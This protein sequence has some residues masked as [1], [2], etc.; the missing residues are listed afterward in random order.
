[1]RCLKN[2]PAFQQWFKANTYNNSLEKGAG[3]TII[4]DIASYKA[5]QCAGLEQLRGVLRPGG[6]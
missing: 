1:M 5:I 3:E 6:A 4:A 2:T